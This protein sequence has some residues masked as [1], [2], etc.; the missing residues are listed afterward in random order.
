MEID[1][2]DPFRPSPLLRRG[3]G[4]MVFRHGMEL[5]PS[6]SRRRQ[7]LQGYVTCSL[8][9]RWPSRVV[10]K[11]REVGVDSAGIS[12]TFEALAFQIPVV[13]G[14]DLIWT[15]RTAD[16]VLNSRTLTASRVTHLYT[17]RVVERFG[18]C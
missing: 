1:G 3:M 13:V 5:L 16:D 11:V 2:A 8:P 18:Q 7:A 6:E 9:D 14:D 4:I 17:A 10:A 12:L 15:I